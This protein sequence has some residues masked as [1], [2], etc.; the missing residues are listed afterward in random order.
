MDK[1]P[2]EVAKVLTNA[3]EAFDRMKQ[4]MDAI[5]VTPQGELKAMQDA[6]EKWREKSETMRATMQASGL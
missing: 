4:E 6:I 3:S 1:Q 2:I 5:K